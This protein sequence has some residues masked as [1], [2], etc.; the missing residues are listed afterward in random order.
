MKKNVLVYILLVFSGQLF[1]QY[2]PRVNVEK[3][4][5]EI[6]LPAH[7]Q[8]VESYRISSPFAEHITYD[9]VTFGKKVA[10]ASLKLHIINNQ[11]VRIQNHLLSHHLQDSTAFGTHYVKVEDRFV[12]VNLIKNDHD[13]IYLSETGQM[14]LAYNDTKHI[15]RDTTLYARVFQVNPINS[16]NVTYGGLYVDNQDQTNALLDAEMVWEAL[17][18]KYEDGKYFLESEFMYFYEDRPPLDTIEYET[19]DSVWYT[20]DMQSFERMNAYFHIHSMGTYI[21]ALGY[22]ALTKQLAVDVHSGYA[23]NS[24]YYPGEHTL[25]FGIGGV[26]DAEDGEV[27]V[28]EYTHSLSETASPEN[29]FGT[30]REAMEEGT[31]DYMAKAYSRTYNDNTPDQIFSWDGHNEYWSGFAINSKRSYPADL[32]DTKDGDRDV[33]SSALMCIHDFIGREATDSLVLEH[34]YYQAAN[35]TMPEMANVI[36]SIDTHSF[37]MRYHGEI[38]QCF[39]DAGFVYRSASVP[40]LENRSTYKVLNQSGFATGEGDLTIVFNKQVNVQIMDSYGRVLSRHKNLAEITL[41]PANYIAG[42]Y[43]IHIEIDGVTFVQKIL[44]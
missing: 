43:L 32:D 40:S 10:F 31:C 1:A 22:D 8:L 12:P 4:L 23:D 11:T 21:N 37:D 26:D 33:W 3:V 44:R 38:K 20:R 14:V 2:L 9:Q 17:P 36:M 42:I 7:T 6:Q 27:V 5:S 18:V 30:E 35:S 19:N 15:K 25:S 29:T 16:A 34:M 24:A 41:Q 28:H 13:F 39:V